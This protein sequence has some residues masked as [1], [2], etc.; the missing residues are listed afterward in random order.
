MK[1]ISRRGLIVGGGVGVGLIVAFAA[2]PRRQVSALTAAKGE[3]IFGDYLKIA[4]DGQV[5]M[6]IPA[7]ET[8]Q[9]IWTG[10]AQIAADELGA[11][12]EQVAVI[13]A[14]AGS[15]Y[16]NVLLDAR[17][18]AGASSVR[19]YERPLRE[20]AAMARDLLVR[21]AAAVWAVDPAQCRAGGG[22]VTFG[23][24]RLGFGQVAEAAA[25]LEPGRPN[26]RAATTGGLSGQT[27]AR[28]DGPAKSDGSWRFASDVRLPRMLFASV[29]MAP[30]GGS[31]RGFARE[32]GGDRLIAG[33]G[34]LAAL[35]ESW[36]A[37]ERTLIAANARFTGKADASSAAVD[38]ALAAA[39][40]SGERRTL[41]VQGDYAETVGDGRALAA[42]YRIAPAEHRAL[43][44]MS[45]TARITGGR[46]E[47]WA[48]VQDHDAALAATGLES[49]AVTLYPMPVGD[50][51]GAGLATAAIPIAIALARRTRRPVQLVIPAKGSRNHLP[52]RSPMLARMTALPDP[53]GGLAAWSARFAAAADMAFP[54]A[55]PPYGV[56]ALRIE[57]VAADLPIATGYMRGGSEAQT[58]F[59]TECFIDEVARRLGSEPFSFRM[60]LLG[61][62]VRLA[63]AL[64]AVAAL[65]RW[66][67]GA[68]G[69]RMGLA[70]ASAFGSH[71]ALLAEAG[72]GPGQAIK[73][74]RMVA[75]VDCGRAIN[76]GLVRQQVEGS[77][78]QAL[79]LATGTP[80]EIVAGMP[81]ARGGALA[82][83]MAVP[84][85][86]VEITPS[87]ADPGGVSGLGHVVLAAAVAN[88]I[89]A[90]T[91]RRLRDLP[92]NSMGG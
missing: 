20:A 65:G 6:A 12:W 18:T 92:F 21:A 11:A 17:R 38:A 3:R 5:T 36:W 74:D 54:G 48:P 59:A 9:G 62:N 79:A 30:P 56:A 22:F 69:S 7:A 57:Q 89:A 70:C 88:A 46:V 23:E 27:L 90:G 15:V 13:P 10:L 39:L 52:M 44:P 66:D 45:A 40:D 55:A 83:V 77:L 29:R 91:G 87:R 2:W 4:P 85:I 58:T 24:R 82:G 73:V 60:G 16:R 42:T 75:V 64:A 43:E 8:G 76:P 35:G 53:A 78:I 81:V 50:P 68:P 25:G 51:S 49:S 14:P 61:G 47:V 33:D 28:L 26:V 80:P 31:L 19:A 32:A 63:Q 67:G 72:F 41:V 71:I 84:R 86:E 1:P 34:W 37:A